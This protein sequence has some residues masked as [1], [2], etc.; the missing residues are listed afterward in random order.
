MARLKL[1]NAEQE[2][3]GTKTAL[4]ESERELAR[5]TAGCTVTGI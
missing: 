3:S 2:L 5:D 4:S 1:R